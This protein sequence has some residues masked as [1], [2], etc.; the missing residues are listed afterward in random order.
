M[1]RKLLTATIIVT[2]IASIFSDVIL[3]ELTGTVPLWLNL[4]KV[5]ILIGASIYF[6][7]DTELKIL[8]KYTI[9][10]AMI[11]GVQM[12]TTFFVATSWYQSAFDTNSF[13]GNF[14]GSIILKFIGAIPVIGLLIY[15]FK[16]PEE[17]YLTKGDLSVRA[18][19]IGWLAIEGNRISWGKLSVIS[20]FL[21]AFG[22]LLLTLLTVTGFT[23]PDNM[24]RLFSYF[25]LILL[26]AFVNS[27]AEGIV[28]RSSILGPLK[29][30]L[31]KEQV[32]LIAAGF[33]G[34]AHYYGAP[35]GVVGVI[36]SGVLGWY[37]CR[38]MYETKGFVSAWIIHFMQ[39]VVIFATIVL[40]GGFS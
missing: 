27:F 26:F 28:Y 32:L 3:Q 30:V 34:M 8:S 16:F 23:I 22:T 40:I 29:G 1:N 19:K 37:M 35:S 10:L 39:D 21:I 31:H 24:D 36:M 12:L 5:V 9:V 38:S 11:V 25:P 14:G 17:V 33:F 2:I 18:G 13:I 20:A 4:V 6:R 15:F 7:I